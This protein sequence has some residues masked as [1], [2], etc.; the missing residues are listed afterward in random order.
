MIHELH[1]CENIPQVKQ[2]L[3]LA[4]HVINKIHQ[5]TKIKNTIKFIPK[6]Q[7]RKGNIKQKKPTLNYS[8]IQRKMPK[9]RGSA[10]TCEG[11]TTQ[12]AAST[13]R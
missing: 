6:K 9:A 1:N 3:S 12:N 5:S 2:K 10:R 8:G 4:K 13:L 11:K 7:G